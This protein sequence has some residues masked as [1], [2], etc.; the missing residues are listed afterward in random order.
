MNNLKWWWWWGCSECQSFKDAVTLTSVSVL[1]KTR[2]KQNAEIKL[3]LFLLCILSK[4]SINS[5]FLSIRYVLGTWRVWTDMC[6]AWWT[7]RVK[8]SQLFVD[9]LKRTSR[10]CFSHFSRQTDSSQCSFFPF[11]S[12]TLL[13]SCVSFN[14]VSVCSWQLEASNSWPA[15][16]YRIALHPR[17]TKTATTTAPAKA[18]KAKSDWQECLLNLSSTSSWWWLRWSARR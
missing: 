3:F 9:N 10:T 11:N 4:L 14:P 17:T 13:C 16:D 18:K 12:F 6:I 2:L 7:L 1:F 15:D 8:Q 5:I